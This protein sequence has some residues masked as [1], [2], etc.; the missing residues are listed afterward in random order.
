MTNPDA[1]V[2]I[3]IVRDLLEIDLNAAIVKQEIV[4]EQVCRACIGMLVN[5]KSTLIARSVAA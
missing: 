3:D 5:L 4:R 2:E 1:I